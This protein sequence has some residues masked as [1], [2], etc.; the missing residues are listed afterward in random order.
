MKTSDKGLFWIL[1]GLNCLD[2]VS[3]ILCLENGGVELNPI[4]VSAIS[5]TGHVGFFVLK[6]LILGIAYKFLHKIQRATLLVLNWVFVV[7]VI[8]NF[9]TY[10]LLQA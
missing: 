6:V 10:F 4:V 9:I 1:V 5:S 7:V 8:L 3:T 2:F